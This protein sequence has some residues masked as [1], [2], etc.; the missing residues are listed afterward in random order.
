[1]RIRLN[2]I[3]KRMQAVDRHDSGRAGIRVA[4]HGRAQHF[5][6]SNGIVMTGADG[7]VMTGADGIVMTGADSF[8]NANAN[9]IVMTGA[10]GIVMTGADGIVMTGADGIRLSKQCAHDQRRRNCDDRR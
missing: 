9:G 5:S 3:A 10:D 8:L 2:S 6:S 4:S 1:M 7:I